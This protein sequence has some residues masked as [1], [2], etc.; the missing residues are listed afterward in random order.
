ML[1][2]VG[3]CGSSSVTANDDTTGETDAFVNRVHAAWP[4]DCTSSLCRRNA[5]E[6]QGRPH[7]PYRRAVERQ[8][9][10]PWT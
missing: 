10:R 2:D 5:D 6:P 8:L 7:R 4:P 9:G 1:A 3:C